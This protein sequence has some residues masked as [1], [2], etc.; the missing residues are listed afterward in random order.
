MR[1][2]CLAGS[3][4]VIAALAG[5]GPAWAQATGNEP[6]GG[7]AA[8]EAIGATLGALVVTALI[9][10]L[11][12]GHRSGRI[13]FLGRLADFAGRQTGLPGWAALPSAV[14]GISLLVAVLGMYWDISLHIDNGRDPGPLANPAHYLILVGLYGT[15]VAGV[16]TMALSGRDRPCDTA[17]H[18]RAGWWAP[19]GGLMIAACG[20][21]ALTGFPLDDIWHRLF[22]QDVT[23][24]GP[25]HLMLIGGGSLATLGAMVLMSEALATV[26]REQDRDRTPVI[27]HVRRALLVG[28]F[29]VALSTFQGE[30][31]F[32][33][34]QF[35]VV[36]QPVLVML[37]AG[38]G[39]VAARI[40]LGRGGALLAVL[41]FLLIRGFLALMVGVV[42]GQ[43]T[44]HFPL[45]IVEALLVEYVFGLARNRSPVGTGAVAGVL[46][47][48]VGLAA[49]WAWTQVWMPIPWTSA[50]LP[51]AIVAGFA[52][53][54]GAGAVGGFV[55]GSLV[56]RSPALARGPR[57]RPDRTSPV[58]R[59]DR[60]TALAGGL[61]TVAVIAWGL[62]LSS[63]GPDRAAVSL[64]DIRSGQQRE[65]AARIHVS[66][67]SAVHDAE[68]LTV[69]SWQ[70]GGR[71][72]DPL[73]RV[74][75]GDYRTT[76][77]IPVY[78][79]WKSLVRFQRDDVIVSVPIYMPEDEAIPAREVPAK[80]TFTRNFQPD[81]EL[82]QRER[83]PGV[84]DSV[85]ASAYL[86]VAALALS[87]FV[88]LGWALTRV[89]ARARL[90]ARRG[91]TGA[92]RAPV[93]P[94]A[95]G[96]GR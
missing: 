41:G 75:P 71:V 22:G 77:P 17:V 31:D 70:G 85:K 83:K 90:Q 96:S 37:A 81:V 26:G 43:T 34:P 73:E 59:A 76:K 56:G 72:L 38:V 80:A 35:R 16:L 79:G 25:T 54:V 74:A 19:V 21:F 45:Y 61:A 51:E 68:F 82:L 18:L 11:I 13:Q 27:L 94:A 44:P 9:A 36:L 8:G 63:D 40:Y 62:P 29:L 1:R 28:G 39:L 78:D 87:L 6:A 30:F 20:A 88:L 12:S 48:T 93:Q 89:D 14:V 64:R 52:T 65:V 91:R 23:L 4:A 84:P 50:L 53:A 49:E 47:G 5:A 7:A 3:S 46:I 57:A 33:V 60:I 55:G 42:W 95:P 2:S 10:A 24:W 86:T 69:T 67:A 66:P 15:L 92:P 58:A 32:G